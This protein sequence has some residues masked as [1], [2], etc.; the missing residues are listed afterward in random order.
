MTVHRTIIVAVGASVLA[1]GLAAP[2]TADSPDGPCPLAATFLC[3]FLPI[4][5][6]LDHNIDLTRESG[7]TN[8]QP[9][10]EMPADSATPDT[11]S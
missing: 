10:P 11:A 9:L 2:A 6:D 5:P 1:L 7:T 4:A 8:G 3:S